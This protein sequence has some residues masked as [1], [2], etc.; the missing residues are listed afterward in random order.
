MI[1]PKRVCTNLCVRVALLCPSLQ[2]NGQKQA[3]LPNVFCNR[4][5][6]NDTMRAGNSRRKERSVRLGNALRGKQQ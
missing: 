5:P 4:E 2:T 3:S 1:L 6:I